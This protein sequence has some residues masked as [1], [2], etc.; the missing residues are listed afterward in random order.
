MGTGAR[1]WLKGRDR[2]V[3]NLLDAARRMPAAG[4]GL[5]EMCA[6]AVMRSDGVDGMQRLGAAEYDTVRRGLTHP[7]PAAAAAAAAVTAVDGGNAVTVAAADGSGGDG[8]GGG[9]GT[10]TAVVGTGGLAAR[11]RAAVGDNDWVALSAAGDRAGAFAAHLAAEVAAAAAAGVV[12]AGAAGA[13]GTA[14]VTGASSVAADSIEH[15]QAGA[16]TRPLLSSTYAVLISEPFCVHFV[17]IYDL[18]IY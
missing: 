8:G 15:P 5:R 9:G 3:G 1:L 10:N 14:R 18:R 17:A 2:V 16:Y 7:A 4:G 13:A 6:E 11:V 12:H